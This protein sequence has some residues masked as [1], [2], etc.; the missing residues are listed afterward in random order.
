M[1]I[2]SSLKDKITRYVDVYI[3]LLKLNFI[4]STANLLSYFLFALIC[5]L[6]L[7][8]IMILLGFGLTEGFIDMGMSRIAALFTTVGIYIFLLLIFMVLRK[9]IIRYF[10]GNFIN[11]LS[12]DA[13]SSPKDKAN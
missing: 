8:C 9:N 2:I 3:K 1:S 13:D 6:L 11:V 4:S 5:L 7:F 10:A 12:D